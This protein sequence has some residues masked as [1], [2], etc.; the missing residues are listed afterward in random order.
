MYKEFKYMFTFDN[1]PNI[2]KVKKLCTLLY[3]YCS[4]PLLCPIIY[5]ISVVNAHLELY[6]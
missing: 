3:L 4:N 2:H 5:I 1:I 6:L